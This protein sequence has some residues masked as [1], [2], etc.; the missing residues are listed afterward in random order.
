METVFKIKDKAEFIADI[1]QSSNV[2]VEGIVDSALL[3]EIYA[4][5]C[6]I[7]EDLEALLMPEED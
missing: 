7:A 3:T 4:K 2:N 1:C 6:D 5:L